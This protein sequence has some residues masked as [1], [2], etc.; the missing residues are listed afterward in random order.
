MSSDSE[1]KLTMMHII[2]AFIAGR[3]K[4]IP[5]EK[6]QTMLEK[7][8][9]EAVSLFFAHQKVAMNLFFFA[10]SNIRTGHKVLCVHQEFSRKY[11]CADCVD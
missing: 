8:L 9:L 10:F 11:P 7:D 2:V 5:I 3:A 1:S 6:R 4:T